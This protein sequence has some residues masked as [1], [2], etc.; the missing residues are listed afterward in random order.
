[1]KKNIRNEESFIFAIY[2]ER[3][4]VNELLLALPFILVIF[5]SIIGVPIIRVMCDIQLVFLPLLLLGPIICVLAFYLIRKKI[6][7][8]KFIKVKDISGKVEVTYIQSE[9]L[10]KTANG[11]VFVFEYSE[12]MKV[13]LYN[14]LLSL[15]VLKNGKLKM[16]KVIYDDY[17]PVRLAVCESDLDI[18]EEAKERYEKETRNLILLADMVNGKVVNQKLYSGIAKNS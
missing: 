10:E 18:P 17:A 16:N 15:N 6:I 4:N 13:I 3:H 14:W 1:M 8:N 11:K 5:Y 12:Y 2:N 9:N 7:I